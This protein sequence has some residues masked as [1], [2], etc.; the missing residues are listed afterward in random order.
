MAGR[1]VYHAALDDERD[2][3]SDRVRREVG[4]VMGPA[5]EKGIT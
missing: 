5:L 3:R 1:E 2:E 4:V